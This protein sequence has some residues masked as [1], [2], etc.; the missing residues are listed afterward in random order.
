MEFTFSLTH[1]LRCGRVGEIDYCGI[2]L[3]SWLSVGYQSDIQAGIAFCHEFRLTGLVG[4]VELYRSGKQ[5]VAQ[6]IRRHQRR[7][8]VGDAHPDRL[9]PLEGLGEVTSGSE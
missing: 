6:R 7:L 3:A 8:I 1:E 4:I 2:L 9:S 5:R